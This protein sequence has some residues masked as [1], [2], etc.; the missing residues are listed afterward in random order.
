MRRDDDAL[1]ER[2]AAAIDAF[3]RDSEE[4]WDELREQRVMQAMRERAASGASRESSMPRRRWA[5]HTAALCAAA[6]VLYALIEMRF[7]SESAPQRIDARAMGEPLDADAPEPQRTEAPSEEPLAEGSPEVQLADGSSITLADGAR[8]QVVEESAAQVRLRQEAGL[9]TYRVSRRPERAFEVRA[10]AVVVRVRGTVF[11]VRIDERGVEVRVREGRVEVDDGARQTLLVGGELLRVR[12]PDEFAAARV[13]ASGA[14]S[15][16]G[17]AS[18]SLRAR[19]PSPEAR[20]ASSSPEGSEPQG[21]SMGSRGP[22]ASGSEDEAPM[23]RTLPVRAGE[24][25]L[26]LLEAADRAR[27]EHRLDEAA[28]LLNRAEQEA[29]SATSRA[30]AAQM[31]ARVERSRGRVRAAA[32]AFDRCAREDPG[33]ALAEGSVA[34]AARAWLAAGD[35]ATATRRAGDYLARWP[36]GVHAASM[37]RIAEE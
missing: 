34:G 6:I 37:R 24:P 22:E 23:P 5:M 35:R 33:G 19:S 14:E 9:A 17:P 36:N 1:A 4:R 21:S 29:R 3:R 11:D 13:T 27:R 10:A 8:V 30:T 18:P 26:D 25:A 16:G 31:L 7:E 12:S 32:E 28:E 20:Q 15:V 2:R